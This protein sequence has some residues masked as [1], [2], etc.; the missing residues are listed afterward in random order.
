MKKLILRLLVVI[1]SVYATGSIYPLFATEGGHSHG[2]A[3]S[4]PAPPPPPPPSSPAMVDTKQP[5][6]GPRM[7]PPPEPGGGG[8]G[9]AGTRPL[10][11]AQQEQQEW[12]HTDFNATADQ[13]IEQVKNNATYLI[14][15]IN[16]DIKRVQD[17]WHQAD[18]EVNQYQDK[19][20]RG[21][22]TNPDLLA[23]ALSERQE[24]WQELQRQKGRLEKVEAWRSQKIRDIWS[25]RDRA[26]N[27]DYHGYRGL[28]DY[29]TSI[30]PSQFK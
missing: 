15:E 1:L 21:T 13:R 11:D 18:V 9:P 23:M 26:K 10:L 5:E 30:H 24:S 7:S 4:G 3:P 27:G 2:P 29:D 28:R 14:E 6:F 25:L 19:K 8:C 17:R 20:R 12:K 16:R 22:L